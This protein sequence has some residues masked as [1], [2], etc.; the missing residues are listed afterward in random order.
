MFTIQGAPAERE[1]WEAEGDEDGLSSGYG[2]LRSSIITT[3][4]T[5]TSTSTAAGD[6]EG[7]TA[8]E[9]DTGTDFGLLGSY[10]K[11]KFT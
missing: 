7:T 4:T 10:T 6:A 9:T 2:V 1:L 3:S 11:G 8:P 5:S